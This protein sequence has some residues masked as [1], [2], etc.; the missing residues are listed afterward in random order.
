MNY[1]IFEGYS[2]ISI[3]PFLLKISLVDVTKTTIFWG[4]GHIYWRRLGK[5]YFLSSECH[6]GNDI[7]S[8][9]HFLKLY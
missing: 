7:L 6:H 4:F 5:L 8:F 9:E 2:K 3:A 1:L